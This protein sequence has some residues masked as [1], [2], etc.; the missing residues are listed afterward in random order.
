MPASIN[1]PLLSPPISQAR[2]KPGGIYEELSDLFSSMGPAAIANAELGVD[3][4]R[5]NF[6]DDFTSHFS[7]VDKD[8]EEF[9]ANLFGE[10]LGAAHGTCVGAL[11]N[12]FLGSNADSLHEIGDHTRTRCNIVLGC[13]TNAS[14]RLKDLW[15]N[16]LCTLRSVSA[17]DRR[18]HGLSEVNDIKEIVKGTQSDHVFDAITLVGGVLYK[19][20]DGDSSSRDRVTEARDPEGPIKKRSIDVVNAEH[21]GLNRR[22]RD[23]TPPRIPRDSEISVGAMYD[24][25][26]MPD[27]GGHAF[28]ID[29]AKLVQPNWCKIDDSLIV[30]WKN[31]LHLRQGTVIVANISIRMHVLHPKN[32]KKPK[33]KVYQGII[34]YLKVV[35]ESDIP[36]AF[37]PQ[38]AVSRVHNAKKIAS[39]QSNAAS[40]L[41]MIGSSRSSSTSTTSTAVSPFT[42]KLPPLPSWNGSIADKL[43]EMHR[44]SDGF[45]DPEDMDVGGDE[46]AGDLGDNRIKAA[47][48]LKTIGDLQAV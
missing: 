7:Y 27:Y 30:P 17:G 2:L 5:Q 42:T 41:R 38:P 28:S 47:K 9:N 32:K 46:F 48:R 11:G 29:K 43:A 45:I 23:E 21:D 6:G 37:P 1:A 31:Y 13:P 4:F 8:S 26:L 33:R 19:L 39:G 44:D 24:P 22:A 35:A 14:R 20:P 34:N 36:V 18:V 3:F 10:I 16:Q 15:H 12:H 25:R 40:V